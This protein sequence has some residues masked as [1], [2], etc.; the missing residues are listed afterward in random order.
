[1]R[2]SASL[3]GSPGPGPKTMRSSDASIAF[4]NTFS[5]VAP[6]GST[7]P[8][9][10]LEVASDA[11]T[12]VVHAMRGRGVASVQAHLESVASPDGLALLERLVDGVIGSDA[13]S[14]AKSSFASATAMTDHVP[15]SAAVNS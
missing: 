1:M 2:G 10:D 15:P 6:D 3:R 13:Y 9:L 14:A 7:T 12:G 8:L 4:Y 5:A 11:T